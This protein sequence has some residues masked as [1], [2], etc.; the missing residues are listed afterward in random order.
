LFSK[1]AGVAWANFLCAKVLYIFWLSCGEWCGEQK[2]GYDA[3]H[4]NRLKSLVGS[5]GLEPVAPAV[6]RRILS[7]F[8]PMFSM[9]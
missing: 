2:S 7:H 6:W 8:M 1:F 3:M 4:H 9:Y 5:T